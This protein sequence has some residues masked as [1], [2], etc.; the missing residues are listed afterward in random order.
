MKP[1]QGNLKKTALES[2][3]IRRDTPGEEKYI[4][5]DR[6]I[7]LS[8]PL[9]EVASRHDLAQRERETH[10]WSERNRDRDRDRDRDKDRNRV[11]GS[12]LENAKAL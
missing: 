12:G 9:L 10:R 6:A 3:K 11:Q 8:A 4:R 1:A 7:T 2:Y 5:F